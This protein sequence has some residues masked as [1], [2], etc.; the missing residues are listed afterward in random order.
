MALRK[1]R[2]QFQLNKDR[3][4]L[5]ANLFVDNKLHKKLMCTN[6]IYEFAKKKREEK[7]KLQIKCIEKKW[8]TS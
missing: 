6:S 1:K 7:A 3:I 2:T 8:E 5:L 4:F